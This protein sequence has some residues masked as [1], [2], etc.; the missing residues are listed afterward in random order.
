LPSHA[1]LNPAIF[2]QYDQT[3]T[4]HHCPAMLPKNYDAPH[5]TTASDAPAKKKE[6]AEKERPEGVSNAERA[7]DL[8]HCSA[9]NASRQHVFQ[10]NQGNETPHLSRF[11]PGC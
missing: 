2:P 4:L 1:T 7:F 5:P 9:E 3:P 8:Q 6:R 10:N 11:S